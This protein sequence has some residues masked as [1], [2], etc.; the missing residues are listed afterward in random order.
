METS[1]PTYIDSRLVIP[2]AKSSLPNSPP[3]TEPPSPK[4]S[5]SSPFRTSSNPLSKPKNPEISIRL[6]SR[7]QLEAARDRHHRGKKIVVALEESL[8]G[9]NLQYGWAEYSF[10]YLQSF[11]TPHLFLGTALILH[12]TRNWECASKRDWKNQ[13][14]MRNALFVKLLPHLDTLLFHGKI[15]ECTNIALIFRSLCIS[16]LW[17][18]FLQRVQLWHPSRRMSSQRSGNLHIRHGHLKL[19][20]TRSAVKGGNGRWFFQC[21]ELSMLVYL[22]ANFDISSV[23]C[24]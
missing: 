21:N 14:T 18:V 24:K 19:W 9:S 7:E 16:Q 23:S 17:L 22:K 2:E 11:L 3:S 1:P 4:R 20:K 15:L 12:L 10:F 6:K 5:P 8:A 13:A